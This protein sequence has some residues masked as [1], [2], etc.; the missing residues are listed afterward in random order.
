MEFEPGGRAAIRP[1]RS[2]GRGAV[3]VGGTRGIGLAVAE[4]LAAQGA[5]VVLNGRDP[6]TA[7]AGRRRD[8]RALA[9]SPVHPSDPDVADASDRH[10]HAASSAASTSW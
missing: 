5:G 10:V 6:D 3:V 7:D 9:A 4:L 1:A 2:T 8:I